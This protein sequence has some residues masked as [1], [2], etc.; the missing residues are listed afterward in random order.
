MQKYHGY[1]HSNGKIIIHQINHQI[2]CA[3]PDV[4]YYI[5]EFQCLENEDPIEKAKELISDGVCFCFK[6]RIKTTFRKKE[7]LKKFL[8]DNNIRYEV[9]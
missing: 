6:I 8:I 4:K 1:L 9:S 3:S 2:D 7:K 5:N